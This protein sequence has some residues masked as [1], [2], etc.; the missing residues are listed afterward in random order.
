M[1]MSARQRY[2]FRNWLLGMRHAEVARGGADARDRPDAPSP[3]TGDMA[4]SH[5]ALPIPA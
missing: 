4:P 5:R 1:P 3:E 2:K